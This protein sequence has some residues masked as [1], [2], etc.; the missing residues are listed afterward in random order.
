MEMTDNQHI[1]TDDF[2]IPLRRVA[3]ADTRLFLFPFAG[4]S[5]HSFHRL[6]E[7]L[8]PSW[9]VFGLQMPGRGERLSHA[10]LHQFSTALEELMSHLAPLLDRP[11]IFWGH[12]LGAIMAYEVARRWTQRNLP[13]SGLGVPQALVISACVAPRYWPNARGNTL[14]I[15]N[16]RD[17][18]L[19]LQQYGD[20]FS[21]VLDDEEILEF[22][23]PTAK[24]DFDVIESYCY[25]GR[26]ELKVPVLAFH[27][28]QDRIVDPAKVQDWAEETQGV[29]TAR[30]FTG[31]H[32][33]YREQEREVVAS[34]VDFLRKQK[35]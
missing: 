3:G 5:A 2:W 14:R 24:A 15:N 29:F 26:A 23:L 28:T 19:A 4:G 35:N 13:F 16:T 11:S 33:F 27:G 32:Y 25:G 12:S 17:L 1:D 34:L 8:P 20:T 9:E 31:G 21:D 6:L 30:A 10:L 22:L 7:H 18:A